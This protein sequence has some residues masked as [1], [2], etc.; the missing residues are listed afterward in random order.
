MYK[1]REQGIRFHARDE[2]GLNV[3]Y[4]FADASF[5]IDKPR[6]GR[7]LFLNGGP[8]SWRAKKQTIVQLSTAAAEIT[9]AARPLP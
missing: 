1:T 3:L 7:V 5:G 6:G 4:A 9:E 8:V 2:M